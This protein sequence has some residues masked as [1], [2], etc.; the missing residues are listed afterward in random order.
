MIAHYTGLGFRQADFVFALEHLTGEN[1]TQ[2]NNKP[3]L[4]FKAANHYTGMF[5]PLAGKLDASSNQH[6]LTLIG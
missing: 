2:R 4:L 3:L 5:Q 1:T 6:R